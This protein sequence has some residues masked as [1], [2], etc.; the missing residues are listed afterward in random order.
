MK[1]SRMKTLLP[2]LL[3]IHLTCSYVLAQGQTLSPEN[4]F[5]TAEGVVT[6]LYRLVTFEVGQT[7]DWDEVES[8]F[9]DEAVIVLRTSRDSTTVFSVEGFIDDFI[10][11]IEP[12][13]VEETGFVE[14]IIRMRP[15]VIGDMAQVLVLYEASIPGSP[16]EPQQGI[17]S[18]LLIKKDAHWRIVAITNEI[19]TPDHPVPAELQK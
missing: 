15:V 1:F 12:A 18:F 5:K 10:N 16:R 2:V 17:D 4:A 13:E 7:P 6:E 8:L 9:I 14:R 11:F 19:P 3:L